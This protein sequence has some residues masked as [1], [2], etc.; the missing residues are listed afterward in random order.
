[1]AVDSQGVVYVTD[2]RNGCVQKFS[3]SGQYIGQ[4]GKLGEEEGELG[5][6]IW[7]CH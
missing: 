3:I 1:M 2:S 5:V 7:Y 6:P 4:F